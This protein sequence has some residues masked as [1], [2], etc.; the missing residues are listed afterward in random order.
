MANRFAQALWLLAGVAAWPGA[1]AA[2]SAASGEHRLPLVELYTAEGC[3]ECPAADRWMSEWARRPQAARPALLALHVDYWDDVG[4]RDRFGAPL[5]SRRQEARVMLAGKR[6]VVTPQ[7]MV[8]E[9]TQV[10]W[11]DA[12]AFDALVAGMRAQPAPMELSMRGTP[13]ED[14]LRV[15]FDAR[16]RDPA[17]AAKQ[18]LLWLALYQD[19]L[20]TAVK[21]GENRG[22]TLRHD[23]VVRALQ[24]PWRMQGGAH[25]GEARLPLPPAGDTGPMGL[26]L[27]AESSSTGEGL[28]ALELPLSACLPQ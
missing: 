19:G 7:V 28:Q 12:R 24:G 26:V 15:A 23:R 17:D 8:G 3:N 16:L 1:Q 11:R 13:A 4:W 25:R 27:F 18:P 2:C 21:A 14:G 6:V 9:R 22:L 5:H 10:D 20:S